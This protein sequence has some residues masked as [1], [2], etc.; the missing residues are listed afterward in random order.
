[1]PCYFR[2]AMALLIC[3]TLVIL[4]GCNVVTDDHGASLEKSITLLQIQSRSTDAATR[5]NCVEALQRCLD[6]RAT[7][8]VEQGLHDAD[9]VV[10]FAAAMAIGHRSDAK[11]YKPLLMDLA[12]KDP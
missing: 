5:A 8:V 7:T 9:W 10:R 12:A 3:S 6:P 4:G 2:F 11:L 1:M